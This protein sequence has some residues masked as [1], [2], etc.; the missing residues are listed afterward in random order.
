MQSVHFNA[1]RACNCLTPLAGRQAGRQAYHMPHATCNTAKTLP[2]MK[3]LQQSRRA[4]NYKNEVICAANR[5]RTRKL[6]DF[7][8]MEANLEVEAARGWTGGTH[9]GACGVRAQ[10]DATTKHKFQ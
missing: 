5:R 4:N 8:Q 1:H 7:A 3:Q 6:L 2:Q 9:S 10:G